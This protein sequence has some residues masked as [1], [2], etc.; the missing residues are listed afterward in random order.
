MSD[1]VQITSNINSVLKEI[2]SF[3]EDVAVRTVRASL[4]RMAKEGQR[5][6]SAATPEH[7]GKLKSNER[8]VAKYAKTRGVITARVVVNTRGK[9]DNPKNAFYWKFVEF[10]HKT[11]PGPHQREIPGRKFVQ[12]TWAVMQSKLYAMFFADLQKAVDRAGKR[13]L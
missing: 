2:A 4:R 13:Y 1:G 5:S 6:L 12:A 9:A 8:V 3:R 11:R 7:T 10:G